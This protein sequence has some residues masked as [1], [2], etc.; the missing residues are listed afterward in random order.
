[1]TF[2]FFFFFY[3]V[4]ILNFLWGPFLHTLSNPLRLIELK[5][6]Y[7]LCFMVSCYCPPLEGG[8]GG[9]QVIHGRSNLQQASKPQAVSHFA[10]QSQPR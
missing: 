6:Y 9:W 7:F 3:D 5:T 10:S 8:Q 2:F 1:M 4:C